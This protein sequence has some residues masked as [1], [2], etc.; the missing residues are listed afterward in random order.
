M[1]R[2]LPLIFL[3]LL[4]PALSADQTDQLIRQL[5]SDD[6]ATRK[7]AFT[8]LAKMCPAI[9]QRLKQ[10]QKDASAQARYSIAKLLR[11][12]HIRKQQARIKKLLLDAGIDEKK[13]SRTVA[14]LFGTGQG[15][16]AA[17]LMTIAKGAPKTLPALFAA[18]EDLTDDVVVQALVLAAHACASAG[19]TPQ[20]SLFWALFKRRPEPEQPPQFVNALLAVADLQDAKTAEAIA[21]L[22][23]DGREL[24]AAEARLRLSKNPSVVTTLLRLV[25]DKNAHVRQQATLCLQSATTICDAIPL[26]DACQKWAKKALKSENDTIRHA[27]A[28]V[29]AHCPSDWAKRMALSFLDNTDD[30]IVVS[31]IEAAGRWR[32]KEAVARLGVFTL[33]ARFVKAAAEAL[34]QIGTE[35]AVKALKHAALHSNT[36]YRAPI[37]DALIKLQKQKT[38]DILL[39]ALLRLK[40]PQE[41]REVQNY[42]ARLFARHFGKEQENA[43]IG[44][45]RRADSDPAAALVAADLL[46]Q[47]GT[48]RAERALTEMMKTPNRLLAV[49]PY[50]LMRGAEEAKKWL[51]RGG[52]ES[53]RAA[54]ALAILGNAEPL[55]RLSRLQ[56]NITAPLKKAVRNAAASARASLIFWNGNPDEIISLKK[57]QSL[58]SIAQLL[59]KKHNLLLRTD[60]GVA[61]ITGKENLARLVATTIKSDGSLKVER[62]LA[63]VV[64]EGETVEQALGQLSPLFEM[65]VGKGVVGKK[66]PLYGVMLDVRVLD[67]LRLISAASG[68]Q[69]RI[70]EGKLVVEAKK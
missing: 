54:E 23:A 42:L 13:A 63:T 18:A 36:P 37:Y 53:F 8:Q 35:E 16:R 30:A 52:M 57:D 70:E 50:C 44:L 43:L 32:M 5:S 66:L 40:T 69:I 25:I 10:A 61:L 39:T 4:I 62:M 1:C 51:I 55:L 11:L 2:L 9:E 45:L 48:K 59:A 3:T 19:S 17:A 64:L 31:G 29:V 21:Q 27:V 41:K 38:A 60:L 46:G 26:P 34:A 68:V 7:A 22:C 20:K 15:M 33:E 49:K 47:F 28:D 12:C 67:A 14:M 6:Y 65:K 24:A 56:E 58:Y